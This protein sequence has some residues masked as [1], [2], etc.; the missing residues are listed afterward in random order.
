MAQ[1]WR[2]SYIRY[3]EY[4]LNITASYKKRPDIRAFLEVILSLSTIT[5]FLIFALKP[6]AITIID[7]LQQIKERRATLSVLTQK[8]ADLEKAN[9]TIQQN[10][11]YIPDI[12][13]AIPSAPSPN[14]FSEQVE[15]L[16]SKDS[17]DILGITINKI[18]I[19]GDLTNKTPGKYMPLPAGANEM[20]FSVSVKGNFA[21]VILFI[22]DF[23]NMRTTS[24]IDTLNINSSISDS[25]LTI[26][27]IIS[28]RAPYMG[29]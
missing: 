28:G 20:P 18:P 13:I 3:R 6:T 7:L 29:K 9:V 21:S 10:Q 14:I 26:V 17:V 15:G 2:G 8:T 12:D 19:V 1:G 5:I 23:Q 24:K 4:F 22:R 25:G 11:N 16:A 27:A